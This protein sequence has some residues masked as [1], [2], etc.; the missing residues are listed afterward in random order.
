MTESKSPDMCRRLFAARAL[1]SAALAALA[2][3]GMG[4]AAHA[5]EWTPTKPLRMVVTF[6]PGGTADLLARA[7][8]PPLGDALGQQVVIDNRAGGG[9]VIG[10]DAVA[11]SGS[12]GLTFGLVAAGSHALNATLVKKLPYDPV[13]DFQWI[14]PLVVTPF[15][16]VVSSA[17]PAHTVAELVANAKA[18]GVPINY[19]T[20]GNGTMN[21]IAGE[22]MRLRT[23][24]PMTHIAYKGGAPAMN[25]IMGGQLD[26]SFL[27]VPSVL[28]FV[29]AGRLRGLAIGSQ[30][31]SPQMPDVPTMAEAGFPGFEAGETFALVAPATMPRAA[32]V[33]LNTEV[34]KLL[35]RPDI[36]DKLKSQGMEISVAGP[37][38]F[39]ATVV[40]YIKDYA[41]VIRR[42]GIESE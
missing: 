40:R 7:I 5:Q 29:Q 16:L 13:K 32:L 18:K 36:A 2:L 4:S 9:G 15:V 33:R 39:D 14:T 35:R 11:R 19:G 20:P 34:V 38:A 12:D 31:R 23:Q 6:P 10:T 42:A 8:A 37:G 1:P 30:Q 21:Q 17:N 28:P 41:E 27:P 25:D 22:N 3:L 24:N 26:M